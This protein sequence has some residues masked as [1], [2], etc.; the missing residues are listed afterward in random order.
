MKS[1]FPAPEIWLAFSTTEEATEAAALLRET[2]LNVAVVDGGGLSALPGPSPLKS[3][4]FADSGFVARFEDGEEE[5]PYGTPTLGVF[6]SPP[7]GFRPSS[8]SQSARP[9]W[10][11]RS[12]HM[13]VDGLAGAGRARDHSGAAEALELMTSLDLYM[14]VDGGTARISIVQEL[15]D[16]AGL[17]DLKR[18]SAHANMETC[19]SEC[20]RLFSEITLDTRLKDVRPRQRPGVGGAAPP[21]EGRKLFSFGSRNLQELLASIAPE[22]KGITQYD[23]GSR[24]ARM[25]L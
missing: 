4:A 17:G 19:V 2:G 25:M 22:L 10:G 6:C 11:R 18:P 14:S 24:L 8:S 13:M 21:H 9:V 3:F 16:F 15:T 23:L 5:F 7:S 12:T 20:E 1:A